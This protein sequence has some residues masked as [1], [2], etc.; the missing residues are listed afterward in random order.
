MKPVMKVGTELEK[1]PS[2]I[3]TI[4]MKGKFEYEFEDGEKGDETNTIRLPIRAAVAQFLADVA[5]GLPPSHIG[6]ATGSIAQYA[7]SNQDV[8]I[9][10][11]S[12]GA[13]Q[14]LAQEFIP[15]ITTSV[16]RVL[17]YMRRIGSS[18]GDLNLSIQTN[19]AGVPSGT[20]VT[21][22]SATPL[23]FNGLPTSLDWVAFDFPAHAPLVASTVYHLVLSSSGYTY[24]SGVT[25]ANW[26]ADQ[27]S[28]G[29]ADGDGETYNGTV[30]SALSPATDFIFRVIAEY[31]S[32]RSALLDELDRNAISAG[33]NPSSAQARLVSVF[34]SAEAVDRISEVGLFDAAA[35]GNLLCSASVDMN[36]GARQV[37]AY[38]IIEVVEVTA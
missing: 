24:D 14:Q 32:A 37:T 10:L 18:T 9:E 12:T 35:S 36:K 38:W 29:Y 4:S 19:N 2:G 23:P 13:D 27:S 30:W 7:R 28:P 22:G 25:E 15:S 6:L 33:T 34:S 3:V 17:L 21:N 8:E 1:R 26:G 11:K 5:P 16:Q 20:V 31:D